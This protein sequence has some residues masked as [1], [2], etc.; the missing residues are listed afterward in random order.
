LWAC[1]RDLLIIAD[2]IACWFACHI[3]LIYVY[4]LVEHG[5]SMGTM[6]Q[7]R[8]P[9]YNSVFEC[10]KCVGSRNFME[11]YG[12]R[13]GRPTTAR[14]AD[15]CALMQNVICNNRRIMVSGLQHDWIW[16]ME[17]LSISSRTRNLMKCVH[18]PCFEY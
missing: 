9:C 1:Q 17:H 5:Y 10:K 2:S 15:N 3:L 14:T 8:S 12:E 6:V 16:H 13:S 18:V 4:E 11:V 7:D